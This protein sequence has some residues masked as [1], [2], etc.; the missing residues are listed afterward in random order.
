MRIKT[1]ALVAAALPLVGVGGGE[2]GETVAKHFRTAAGQFAEGADVVQNPGGATE[3][4][5]DE[6]VL[7]GV[8]FHVGYLDGGEV[9]GE[10][11]P[12]TAAVVA[13]P[14]TLVGAEE[15]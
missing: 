7:A 3:G 15:E 11:L 4:A 1:D 8:D 5:D 13:N 9:V 2:N 6:V 12:I 10:M 14:Q